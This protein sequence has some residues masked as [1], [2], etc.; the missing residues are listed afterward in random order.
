MKKNVILI[1]VRFGSVVVASSSP[2]LDDWKSC[3]EYQNNEPSPCLKQSEC[4][5]RNLPV[6][7]C[8]I[9]NDSELEMCFRPLPAPLKDDVSEKISDSLLDLSMIDDCPSNGMKKSIP[10]L[11][12]LSMGTPHYNTICSLQNEV[13]QLAERVSSSYAA[14]YLA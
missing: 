9:V 3:A 11:G 1:Q 7:K 12:S 13:I 2:D 4:V 14:V 5:P 6:E 10:R 8:R